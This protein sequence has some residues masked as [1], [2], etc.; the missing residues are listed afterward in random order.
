MTNMDTFLFPKWTNSIKY[1]AA[2]VLAVFPLYAIALVYYA[3]SPRT[4]DVGY[5]PAQPVLYSHALHVGELGI[6]CHYCHTTVDYA[7]AAAIPPTQT[8]MNCH[9]M[10]RAESPK[11]VSVRES[12]QSGMPIEWIRVH[13]L[14]DY[15]YFNHSAHVT[16]GIGCASCHQRIDKMEV[17]YQSETL[18]M[19][20]CLD[21]HRKPEQHL[22]PL[23]TITLMDWT[24]PNQMALGAQL[25]QEYTINPPQDCS[26]CHR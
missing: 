18:S 9:Q 2:A 11:L 6:D 21:C 24:P 12:Y 19:G 14:P 13:D 25:R 1:G 26:T 4:T 23:D 10:I 20:W 17:V 5:A 22:R 7:A 3:G 8:C 16:R 15:A